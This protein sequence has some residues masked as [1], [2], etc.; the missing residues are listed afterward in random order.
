MRYKNKIPQKLTFL[1][2]LIIASKIF[3]VS[4]VS[5]QGDQPEEVFDLD[6]FQVQ[7]DRDDGFVAATSLAGGR[8]S[9]ELSETAAAYSVQ[10]REFLDA[11][12]ISDVNE[13]LDW[14]VNAT[15]TPDAG[16]GQLFG[17]TGSSTIRG[18]S[19]NNQ[20]RNFFAGGSNAA[21][22][23]VERL[24]YARG[25][26]SSLFGTGS[27]SGTSN[28]MVKRPMMQ[29]DQG[30]VR[31]QIGSWNL[32]RFNFDVNRGVGR[33]FA[34]RV[35]GEWSDSDSWRRFE[36]TK[37]RGFAPGFSWRINN[38]TRFTVMG[39]FYQQDMVRGMTMLTNGF[40]GW[41][42]VTTYSGVQ[43]NTNQTAFGAR[44]YGRSSFV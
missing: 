22:Y 7:V 6:P 35:T 43:P 30:N 3:T 8:M 25:P 42:G 21:S 14:T 33:N 44:R 9:T 34:I 17:G 26:N 40:S 27:I 4:T 32:Q 36:G 5:A 2:L 39:D 23:N 19:T 28:V 37:R 10:T 12:N 1:T 20:N 38:R 41:D 13:A 11:L 15:T 24:D 31:Y 18:V 29:T 16:E